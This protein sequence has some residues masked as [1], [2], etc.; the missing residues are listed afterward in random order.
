MS[1]TA[2]L[3]EMFEAGEMAYDECVADGCEK[4]EI[5]A[6][7][8]AAMQIMRELHEQRAAGALIN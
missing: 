2:I 8:Y 7:V 4:R 5:V 3:E 1:D 6:A